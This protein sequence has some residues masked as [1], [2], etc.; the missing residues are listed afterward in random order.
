VGGGVLAGFYLEAERQKK[1]GARV[2]VG[3]GVKRIKIPE[4]LKK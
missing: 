3:V 4:R 1:G 2:F